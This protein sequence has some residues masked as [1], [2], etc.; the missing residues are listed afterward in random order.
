MERS[1]FGALVGSGLGALVPGNTN[2][3][4]EVIS[5]KAQP[6]HKGVGRFG[7]VKIGL[8]NFTFA[9]PRVGWQ[10]APGEAGPTY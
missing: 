10:F 7:G 5:T 9:R 3:G 6:S 2:K 4:V 1:R 8:G